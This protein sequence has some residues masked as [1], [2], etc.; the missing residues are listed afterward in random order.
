[1]SRQT[2]SVGLKKAESVRHYSLNTAH[3]SLFPTVLSAAISDLHAIAE[4]E[5]H[6]RAEWLTITPFSLYAHSCR[7]T[8]I[9]RLSSWYWHHLPRGTEPWHDPLRCPIYRFGSMPGTPRRGHRPGCWLLD[10]NRER[11]IWWQLRNFSRLSKAE[12]VHL[13]SLQDH[14]RS[15]DIHASFR[16]WRDHH[17]PRPT[18]KTAPY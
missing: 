6:P 12:L 1:M 15:D 18:T 2:L 16:C 9:G 11:E 13:R 8:L 17:N 3:R 7:Q 5:G 4:A 14:G 10:I